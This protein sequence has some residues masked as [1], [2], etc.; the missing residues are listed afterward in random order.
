MTNLLGPEGYEG[1]LQ[2][3]PGTSDP[4][5]QLYWYDKK[6]SKPRRKLGHVTVSSATS[7][8]LTD[9]FKALDQRIAAWDWKQE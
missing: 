8:D 4:K 6:T 3:P 7:Q 1:P 5:S 2:I 9:H